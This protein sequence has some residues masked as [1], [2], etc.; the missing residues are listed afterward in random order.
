MNAPTIKARDAR[1]ALEK[2]VDEIRADVLRAADLCDEAAQALLDN[3]RD[4]AKVLLREACDIEF[5][6]FGECEIT[7]ALG[8]ALGF[9]LDG[10]EDDD[11]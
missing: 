7:G 1:L 10:D 4:V 3:K 11:E 5:D 9:D 6:V 2:M 8:E